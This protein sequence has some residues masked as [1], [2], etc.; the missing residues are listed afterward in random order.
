MT[1]RR[2]SMSRPDTHKPEAANPDLPVQPAPEWAAPELAPLLGEPFASA[3]ASSGAGA[4]PASRAGA[5]RQRLQQRT[6][7]SLA[8]EGPMVTRRWQRSRR[9]DLAPGVQEVPLYQAQPG[10]PLRAGE[11]LQVR[12]LQLQPGA[13]LRPALLGDT[14]QLQQ[15]HR[16]WLL[17]QGSAQT[18]PDG[19]WLSQRDYHVN[20]AGSA[21]PAWQAGPAGARIFLREADIP[22]EPGEAAHTVRDSQAGWP[23]F[24]PGLR[25]RVLWQR[26][27]QAALLYHAEP[28]ASVPLHTHGHDEECLMLQGELFL[29]DLLLQPGDWQL[30]PAGTGH[31]TTATDT[32]VVIYA[33]GDLDLKFV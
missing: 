22:A 5:L 25:R 4:P 31:H 16:E 13:L 11:P 20:P 17:L 23:A 9:L 30:A 26:H 24:A 1:H 12:L 14:E 21:T 27:G 15:R 2:Q 6:A 3:W 33:H 18:P 8:A 7:A 28:G 32:G 10:A 19:A 29:D